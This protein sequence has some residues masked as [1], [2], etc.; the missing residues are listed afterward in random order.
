VASPA[1]L[2]GSCHYPEPLSSLIWG[3]D[4]SVNPLG[5][6]VTELTGFD[7]TGV[8][9]GN[10]FEVTENSGSPSTGSTT[11]NEATMVPPIE[12]SVTS[13]LDILGNTASTAVR[14]WRPLNR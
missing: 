1:A 6:F 8:L 7:F 9:N 13:S 3:R 2:L 11:I 10:S 4:P 5:T 14:S 12:Y